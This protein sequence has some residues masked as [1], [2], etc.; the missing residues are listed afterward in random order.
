MD[1]VP[2]W[3]LDLWDKMKRNAWEKVK[4]QYAIALK[5][6]RVIEQPREIRQGDETNAQP[7]LKQ[8]LCKT[9][10]YI[11][12]IGQ[13][14]TLELQRDEFFRANGTVRNHEHYF[15]LE[16]AGSELEDFLAKDSKLNEALIYLLTDLLKN[17]QHELRPG[18][19][20]LNIQILNNSDP[21]IP[22][23]EMHGKVLQ[24]LEMLKTF[25]RGLNLSF[26]GDVIFYPLDTEASEELDLDVNYWFIF[27]D[28]KYP[29]KLE[30]E[31]SY[32]GEGFMLNVKSIEDERGNIAF[33]DAYSPKQPS[34][35]FLQNSEITNIRALSVTLAVNPVQR[36]EG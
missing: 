23:A 1:L 3:Q 10:E 20:R 27:I 18:F 11:F 25:R 16:I 8:L 33:I 24:F 29:A 35:Y 30:D 17:Y 2:R 34:I 26:K 21:T 22:V 13:N 15:S 32:A 14:S 5:K 36:E 6:A 9:T 28:H 19:S 12:S 7:P 31:D 4:Q